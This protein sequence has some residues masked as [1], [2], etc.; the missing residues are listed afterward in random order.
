MKRVISNGRKKF[1]QQSYYYS[2]SK[3]FRGSNAL[4][5]AVMKDC[6]YVINF[7]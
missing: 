1:N 7:I 3:S 4:C 2:M 6:S 5:M